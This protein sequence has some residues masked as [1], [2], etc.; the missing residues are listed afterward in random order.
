MGTYYIPNDSW[1]APVDPSHHQA[2]DEGETYYLCIYH[3][4]ILH[5]DYELNYCSECRKFLPY[6]YGEC[7]CDLL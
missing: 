4:Y 1:L 2:C 5:S 6:S 3:R 7:I